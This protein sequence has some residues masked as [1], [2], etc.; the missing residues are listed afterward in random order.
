MRVKKVQYISV[1]IALVAL[2]LIS[3][4]PRTAYADTSNFTYYSV[5]NGIVV[6]G[7]NGDDTNLTIPNEINGQAVVGIGYYAFSGSMTLSSVVIPDS[8]KFIGANTFS[9]CPNLTNVRFM[10]NA[11]DIG[12][13]VLLNCSPELVIY[14]DP[15]KSGFSSSWNGF[16]TEAYISD[17]EIS[18]IPQGTS[19]TGIT[20]DKSSATL[21]V[22]ENIKLIPTISPTDATNQKII[23]TSSNPDIAAV[24]DSG[25]ITALM[26]GNAIITATTEDG[27]FT[28][29]CNVSVFNP[30]TTPADELAIPLD[31]NSVKV[32]WTDN[33]DADGYDVYR[34]DTSSGNY[35]SIATVQTNEYTDTS[36]Q[37]GT[38]YYYKVRAYR[39]EEDKKIYSD[40]TPIISVKTLDISIGSTLFLFMSDLD[41]RN[42]VLARAIA[43]HNGV[44]TNNCALTV[45][46]AFRR[47]SVNIPTSTFRT[48][49][50][51]SN[52]I[53]R[54][55]VRSMDLSLLQPGDICFTT[56]KYGNLLG[57]HSTHVFIFM[58]WA[59]KDKT[60]MNICDNQTGRYGNVLHTRTIFNTSSTDATAFFYHTNIPDAATILKLPVTV[61]ANPIAYNKVQITWQ[62]APAAYGY[63]IYRSTLKY[64][65]YANVA[66]TRNTSIT[67]SGLTPGR[68]YYYKVRAYNNIDTSTIYGTF[69]DLLTATPTL[70]A[71]STNVYSNANNKVKLSWSVVSGASGYQIYRSTSINGAYTR[72]TST[73]STSYTK[74]GLTKGMNYYYKVRA[75]KYIGKTIVYSNYTYTNFKAL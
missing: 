42:S 5:D 47:L 29:T 1:C 24:D 57:G 70:S 74:T 39:T 68:T 23:W 73:S 69:S 17:P 37:T 16:K 25:T 6:T 75:Y 8:L 3:I 54:G 33:P 14:Y 44:M 22:G 4:L 18:P 40:Y 35:I 63:K 55:W 10:G 28:A 36:L 43:L 21:T 53:A 56:D 46:E 49:Q 26:E 9:Y 41:N 20:L 27:G 2:L 34:L 65:T 72:V 64:G 59:N 15:D 66:T 38:I 30:L 58:G 52:L 61:L 71:P 19:V 32:S 48:N 31:Y 50:V 13:Q 11:P 60:L 62:A 67:D 7:Y 45:S 51:E 12:T